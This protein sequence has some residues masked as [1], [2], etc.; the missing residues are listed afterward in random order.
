LTG[1]AELIVVG[2]GLMGLATALHAAQ[3][4][5]DVTI[6]ERDWPGR[7]ASGA[8]AGGVRSLNRHDAEIPLARAAL[9]IWR[10]L[11]DL[12]GDTGGFLASG[13]VRVA[14]DAA[15]AAELQARVARLEAMGYDHER[16][17][18]G[19]E[20]QARIPALAPH[21]TG[22][23]VVDDDGHADPH[24]T[25]R[26]FAAAVRRQGVRV[27]TGTPVSRIECDGPDLAVVT[28]TGRMTAAMVV[29]AAGAWGA[30]LAESVGDHVPL[31]AAAL[32]ML[33]TDR[34]PTFV[35]PVVGSAG[36][37]L[38]FKQLPTGQVVI[39]GGFEGSADSATGRS[40]LDH[41]G[42]ARN[43]ANARALFPEPLDRARIIRAWAGIEGVTADGLPVIDR[44]SAHQG[45]VHAFGFSAHGF[46]LSPLV[47]RLVTDLLLNRPSNL[48]LAPFALDRFNR[49]GG[50]AS[51]STPRVAS[52]SSREPAAALALPSPGT[53]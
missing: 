14:E 21:C 28:P 17:I 40:T 24:R 35:R 26:A 15:Q 6:L 11:E 7:H 41:A 29:N 31:T 43:V 9:A 22:A 10:E 4:G 2:G 44:S 53:C 8:N 33:V 12:V 39:G 49:P 25:T 52:S 30:D 16:W 48:D 5:L 42:L 38:S 18:G 51:C 20:L 23:I 32:Q 45:L 37:K 50:E 19:A 47:G 34:L 1:K 3:A 27:I 13:Q 46:A 36:R